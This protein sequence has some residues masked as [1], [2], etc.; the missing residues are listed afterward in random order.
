MANLPPQPAPGVIRRMNLTRDERMSAY[1]MLLGMTDGEQLAR[2]SISTVAA[3]FNINRSTLSRL[4]RQVR[5]RRLSNQNLQPGEQPVDEYATDASKRRKG[6]YIHDRQAIKQQVL[7]L[8]PSRR[9]K[10]RWLAA[11]LELPLST[12]HYLTKSQKIFFKARSSIKPTL[13]VANKMLRIDHC[14]SKIDPATANDE[15]T[16]MKYHFMDKE[17]HIDEK[18]FYLCRD[19]ASYILVTDEEEPPERYVKHK[20]HIEKVMFLCAQARPRYY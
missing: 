19:G 12:V 17:V 1:H 4:W 7:Q 10:Y 16:T 5:E 20:S 3:L 11:Q 13:T 8:S 9:Q 2:G 6:K 15:A 18:W 14:L